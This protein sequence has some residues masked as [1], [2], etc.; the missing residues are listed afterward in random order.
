MGRN[1]GDFSKGFPIFFNYNL[2]M[3][4]GAMTGA[5]QEGKSAAKI[6]FYLVAQAFQPAQV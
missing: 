2:F 1:N 3:P 6:P 5:G 4:G